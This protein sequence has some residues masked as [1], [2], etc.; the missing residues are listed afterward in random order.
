M[1]TSDLYRPHHRESPV[2]DP[3]ILGRDDELFPS[4]SY[5]AIA[6]TSTGSYHLMLSLLP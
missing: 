6:I 1:A 2:R 4:G 5:I 3:P